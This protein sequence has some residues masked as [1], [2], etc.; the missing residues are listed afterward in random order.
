MAPVPHDWS[1]LDAFENPLG[2]LKFYQDMR[3]SLLVEFANLPP[4][5]NAGLQRVGALLTLCRNKIREWDRLRRVT[6]RSLKR[7]FRN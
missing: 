6:N 2:R 7:E 3:D 5:D 1:R 4:N